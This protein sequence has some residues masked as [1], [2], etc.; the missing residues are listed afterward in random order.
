MSQSQQATTR[1]ALDLDD[2]ERQL[3]STASAQPKAP[4]ADP[5]AELARI[6]GQDDPFKSLKAAR[7][8]LAAEPAPQPE[9]S[10]PTSID[11]LLADLGAAKPAGGGRVEPNFDHLID[12]FEKSLAQSEEAR[13][14]GA[15]AQPATVDPTIDPL[16]EFDDLLR[17]ELK[18]SLRPTQDAEEPAR[19]E[20]APAEPRLRIPPPRSSRRA[21]WPR[22]PVCLPP[23]ASP[24]RCS[25]FRARSLTI[26]TIASRLRRI[27]TSPRRRLRMQHMRRRRQRTILSR[28]PKPWTTCVRSSLQ[29]AQSAALSSRGPCCSSASSASAR[30]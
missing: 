30:W 24:R 17:N 8:A 28:Q 12:D 21:L 11:D 15:A 7:P 3:R 5:L 13:S 26:S 1:F 14:R 19:P 25:R 23:P 18:A 27:S 4:L 22:P 20:P 29:Q 16:G 10:R 9:P 2:L 6:V